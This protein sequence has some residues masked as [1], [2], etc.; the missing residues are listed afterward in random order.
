M[1]RGPQPLEPSTNSFLKSF[2]LLSLG[3]SPL[4]GPYTACLNC[5]GVGRFCLMGRRIRMRSN[6][7]RLDLPM[8]EPEPLSHALARGIT[9]IREASFNHG[10]HGFFTEAAKRTK[11]EIADPIAST[12]PAF[13]SIHV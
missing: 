9:L 12:V 10:S 4:S 13:G 11:K 1:S 8:G 6:W 2:S 3:R 5:S 7:S